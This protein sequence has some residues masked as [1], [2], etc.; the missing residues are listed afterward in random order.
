M[1]NG[2]Y[3]VCGLLY[4]GRNVTASALLYFVYAFVCVDVQSSESRESVR[5]LNQSVK[6]T[7]PDQ[8]IVWSWKNKRVI[9][10]VK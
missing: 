10:R 7:R 4:V 5:G 1:D 6:M 8:S 2:W 9:I 3:C